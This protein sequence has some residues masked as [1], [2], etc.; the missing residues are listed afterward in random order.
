MYNFSNRLDPVIKLNNRMKTVLSWQDPIKTLIFGCLLTF[1]IIYPRITIGLF[2][3]VIIFGR[4]Y[5]INKAADYE[6][7]KDISKRLIVP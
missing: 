6:L 3:M 4:H 1:M 2:G 7:K 5:I